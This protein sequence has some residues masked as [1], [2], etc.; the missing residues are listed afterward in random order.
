[1]YSARRYLHAA[2]KITPSKCNNLVYSR[3]VSMS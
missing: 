3:S 1:M 2:V